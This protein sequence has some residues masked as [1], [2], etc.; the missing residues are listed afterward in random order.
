MN[1]PREMLVFISAFAMSQ[2]LNLRY[3][4]GSQ[5][6]FATIGICALIYTYFT[7]VLE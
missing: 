1:N 7:G 4:N 5:F 6:V 3:S 2:A